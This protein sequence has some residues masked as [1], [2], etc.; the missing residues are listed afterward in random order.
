LP[1]SERDIS[2]SRF[3]KRERVLALQK[4]RRSARR[5]FCGPGFSNGEEAADAWRPPRVPVMRRP[6]LWRALDG[7]GAEFRVFVA[8]LS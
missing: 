7:E 4:S 8:D 5:A 2:V 3:M 6:L 1:V